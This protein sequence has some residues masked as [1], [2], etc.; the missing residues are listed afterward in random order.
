MNTQMKK[1]LIVSLVA[2]GALVVV[3]KYVKAVEATAEQT[4]AAAQT[5]ETPAPCG[6]D[7]AD[8]ACNQD[9]QPSKEEFDAFMQALKSEMDEAESTDEAPSA[10]ETTK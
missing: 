9:E 7:D 10:D 8:C 3:A 6:C 1:I 2:L 5:V 4:P